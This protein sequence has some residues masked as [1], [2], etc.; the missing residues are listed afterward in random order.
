[1]EAVMTMVGRGVFDG[2]LGVYGSTVEP[3]RVAVGDPVELEP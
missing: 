2:W 3:G 1:M